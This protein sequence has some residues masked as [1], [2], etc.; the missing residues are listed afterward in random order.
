MGLVTQIASL[1]AGATGSE[2]HYPQ[3]GKEQ[4]TGVL[5]I[6][7]VVNVVGAGATIDINGKGQLRTD[8]ISAILI[9][10]DGTKITYDET[11]FGS[12][13]AP[14]TYSLITEVILTPIMQIQ[15]TGSN[16]ATNVVNA[17]LQE[18]V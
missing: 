8:D 10:P 13:V 5:K 14:G 4:K 2:E 6:D 16:D 3:L 1:S 17:Y 12:P 9:R 11:D 18:P 7:W 15:A